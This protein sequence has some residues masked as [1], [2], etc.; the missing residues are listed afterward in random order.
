MRFKQAKE[1]RSEVEIGSI[2]LKID[3]KKICHQPQ[4]IC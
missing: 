3:A 4:D 1:N 2:D